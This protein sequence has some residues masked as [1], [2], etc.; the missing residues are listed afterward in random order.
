MATMFN[1]WLFANEY[2][3]EKLQDKTMGRLIL[4]FQNPPR[5]YKRDIRYIWALTTCLSPL[6]MLIAYGVTILIKEATLPLRKESRYF[7]DLD[8]LEGFSVKRA[9]AMDQWLSFRGKT[10]KSFEFADAWTVF[11][12]QQ[13]IKDLLMPPR[14]VL[15]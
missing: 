8:D 9:L 15:D 5:L 14:L 13:N 7:D 3:I 4:M 1:L 10:K 6:R 2:G 12:E 11:V